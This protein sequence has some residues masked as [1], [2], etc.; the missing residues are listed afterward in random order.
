M[1]NEPTKSR[2]G[3]TSNEFQLKEYSEGHSVKPSWCL[4]VSTMYLS[5]FCISNN[6][7]SITDTQQ[8]EMIENRIQMQTKTHFLQV[9]SHNQK[10]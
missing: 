7:Y 4:V 2:F 10:F 3:P 8:A 1:R 5:Q 9:M 6:F